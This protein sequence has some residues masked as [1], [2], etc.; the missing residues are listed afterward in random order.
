MFIFLT[1]T[2]IVYSVP[3]YVRVDLEEPLN[4]EHI[5]D[6]LKIYYSFNVVYIIPEELRWGPLRDKNKQGKNKQKGRKILC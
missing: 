1:R 3:N 4:I 5:Y 6:H 2:F